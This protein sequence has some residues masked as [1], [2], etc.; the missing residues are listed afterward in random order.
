MNSRIHLLADELDRLKIKNIRA[1]CCDRR[2]AN[3]MSVL[4]ASWIGD[5][6]IID[7]SMLSVKRGHFKSDMDLY[8]HLMRS[9]G[10]FDVPGLWFYIELYIEFY[11]RGG[12]G[13]L[14]T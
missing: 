10:M 8:K 3:D 14:T 11:K 4:I 7:E 13:T 2:F 12:A 6:G 1:R 5:F 9:I